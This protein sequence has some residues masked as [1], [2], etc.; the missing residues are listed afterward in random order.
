MNAPKSRTKPLNEKSARNQSK[1]MMEQLLDINNHSSAWTSGGSNKSDMIQAAMDA[2]CVFPESSLTLP[3]GEIWTGRTLPISI[4][5]TSLEP[6]ALPFSACKGTFFQFAIQLDRN[7]D[8]IPWMLASG[9]DPKKF[10]PDTRNAPIGQM[11]YT[12]RHQ[13]LAVCRR[14]GIDLT[15]RVEKHHYNNIDDKKPH[16]LVGSTLLHRI[17][18]RFDNL[19]NAHE[20]MQELLLA[21]LD[22]YAQNAVGETP[23]DWATDRARHELKAWISKV[24]QATLNETTQTTPGSRHYKSRL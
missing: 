10:N 17:A 18:E 24:E 20:V 14:A 12:G 3:S 6:S 8:T 23:I 7:A 16:T 19:P 9:F 11:A 22:P 13:A 21:G 15:L 5:D 2:L 4:L 1:W